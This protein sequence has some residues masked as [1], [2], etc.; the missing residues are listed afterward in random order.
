MARAKMGARDALAAYT[1]LQAAARKIGMSRPGLRQVTLEVV[2]QPSAK[3]KKAAAAPVD[4]AALLA[5][6]LAAVKGATP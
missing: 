4:G 2:S 5:T 6:M 1:D 3:A